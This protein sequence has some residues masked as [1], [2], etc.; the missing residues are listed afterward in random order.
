MTIRKT[1]KYAYNLAQPQLTW[2]IHHGDCLEVL[3]TL[4][5]DAFDSVVTDVPYGLSQATNDHEFIMKVLQAWLTGNDITTKATGYAGEKWDGLC[6]SPNVWREVFRVLKPGGHMAVFAAPRTDDLVKIA[7][8]IAG[9]EIIDTISFVVKGGFPKG[10]DMGRAL[11]QRYRKSG[12]VPPNDH[13]DIKSSFRNLRGSAFAK[14]LKREATPQR[15]TTEIMQPSHPTA[16]KWSDYHSHLKQA[17]QPITIARKPIWN[18]VQDNLIRY[19]VGA[20]NIGAT[21]IPVAENDNRLVS[22]QVP[23]ASKL[24]RYPC[25]IVG[26]LGAENAAHFFNPYYIGSRTMPKERDR[27]MPA[28]EVNNHPT[29][30]PIELLEWLIRLVT[31]VGGKVLDPYAGSGTTGIAAVRQGYQF[32]GIEIDSNYASIANKRIT[33]CKRRLAENDLKK[34]AA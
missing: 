1:K 21:R 3:K 30:K 15:I 11:E 7:L 16:C 17:F 32:V 29:T 19:Q 5:S 31:P 12:Y 33:E 22:S 24:G 4:P 14:S 23:D 34:D 8:R 26:D 27:Y 18:N 6:P 2:Q 10:V 25:N 9:F 20:L 13:R 28:G